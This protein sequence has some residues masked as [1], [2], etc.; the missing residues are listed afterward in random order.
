[1]MQQE[2]SGI[3]QQMKEQYDYFDK[4]FKLMANLLMDMQ[5]KNEYL[6][7]KSKQQIE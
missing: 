6:Y 4:Q 5:N 7:H 3:K 1:M 2:I